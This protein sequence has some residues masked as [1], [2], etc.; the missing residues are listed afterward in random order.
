MIPVLTHRTRLYEA[1]SEDSKGSFGPFSMCGYC[2]VHILLNKIDLCW[3]VHTCHV[4]P[5]PPF[6]QGWVHLQIEP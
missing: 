3:V 5:D 6:P 2:I 4:L 1:P